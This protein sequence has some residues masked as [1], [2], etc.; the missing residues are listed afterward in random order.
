MYHLFGKGR[1]TLIADY[2][3]HLELDSHSGPCRFT[4]ER[5]RLYVETAQARGVQEI[6]ITEHCNRFDAFRPFMSHLLRD[7]RETQD[8]LIWQERSF[9]EDLD[10]YVEA[11]LGAKGAGLPIKL[12]LEVDFLPEHIDEV[13]AVLSKY[14]WDYVLG[15][16]H[17]LG[18]WG[19]DMDPEYGWPTANVDA[20]YQEYFETLVAAANSGLFH[21][22]AHPDLVKKFGHHP[23]FP[24]D[25]LYDQLAHAAKKAD[26]AMEISTAGL[27]KPVGELYPSQDLL[28]RCH[29]RGVPITLASDAHTPEHVARDFDQALALA[30]RVG[31]DSMAIFEQGNRRFSHLG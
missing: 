25:E 12:S 26:V 15:S 27:H 6:G 7:G 4:T 21:V 20:V 23:S 11:I 5:M 24:L 14:P 18:T 2:H 17:F 19:I 30:R 16:V 10:A 31:Y 28:Q 1:A 29:D 9:R 8:C 13:R 3:M 22:L